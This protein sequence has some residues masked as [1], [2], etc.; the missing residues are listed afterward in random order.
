[1]EHVS[2]SAITIGSEE[3]AISRAHPKKNI[4]HTNQSRDY[5]D[6]QGNG[7]QDFSFESRERCDKMSINFGR[8]TIIGMPNN[9]FINTRSITP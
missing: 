2:L 3:L 5:I 4:I 8:N 7:D 6:R 9:P 1:M